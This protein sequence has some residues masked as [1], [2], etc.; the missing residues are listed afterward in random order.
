MTFEDHNLKYQEEQI[1]LL[2]QAENVD[3]AERIKSLSEIR[4]AL[5]IS[6][7][8]KDFLNS[9]LGQF[10]LERAIIEQDGAKEQLMCINRVDFSDD[11]AFVL[12]I[13]ELQH[14]AH[15]PGLIM[16]W[17]QDAICAADEEMRLT[18][19]TEELSIENY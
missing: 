6:D 18:Q 19:E 15:T 11:R 3:R 4:E 17:I 16:T 12:K 5:D 7:A 13:D 8:C 10:L 9:K 1:A 14:R 2:R